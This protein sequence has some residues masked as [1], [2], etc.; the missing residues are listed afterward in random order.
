MTFDTV[1]KPLRFAAQGANGRLRPAEDSAG[2]L[3]RGAFSVILI[4]AAANVPQI[5]RGC[6]DGGIYGAGVPRVFMGRGMSMKLVSWNVNGLRACIGKGF[7]EYFKESAADV[8]CIQE[9]KMQREQAPLDLPDY[10]QYWNSAVKKG[11]SGTA[12]FSRV[13]PLSAAYGIGC[14]AFDEEGRAI[15]LEFEDFYLLNLY[16]PNAQ[17]GLARIEYR[18]EWEDAL[19]AYAENL[20]AE[21]PVILC[22]DMNVARGPMDLKNPRANEGN[23]G[24]SEQE[25][26]K[27]QQLLSAGFTDVFRML[28]PDAA[29]AY[30]WWSYVTHARERNAGWRIDYF[31]CSNRFSGRIQDCILRPDV[32]GSDHCPVELILKG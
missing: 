21:K 19:R 17:R 20:D 9:T 15:T 30:T 22:G 26:A 24:Y 4:G 29:D 10:G 7:L 18:M 16:V 12:V 32:F 23:A 11:Y 13:A 14:P 25:R 3:C 5:G 1:H 27:M 8:C 31:L 6:P 28:Y 2:W